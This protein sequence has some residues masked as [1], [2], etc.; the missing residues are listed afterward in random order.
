MA[1]AFPTV[2]WQHWRAA[3][4]TPSQT[5]V[6][7]WTWRDTEPCL[8]RHRF[9]IN[10]WFHWGFIWEQYKVIE[11]NTYQHGT[12]ILFCPSWVSATFTISLFNK[13]NKIFLLPSQRPLFSHSHFALLILYQPNLLYT[14]S[15]LAP[16]R[17]FVTSP[18]AEPLAWQQNV[19]T[20]FLPLFLSYLLPLK[21]NLWNV[22]CFTLY[23]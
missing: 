14:F 4:R 17:P 15:A 13:L 22:L 6:P 19:L 8:G 1:H 11:A 2:L 10:T 20:F 16:L 12:K 23:C 3:V 5:G 9:I 21:L 7:T 18:F